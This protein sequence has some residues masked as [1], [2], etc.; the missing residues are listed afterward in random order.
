MSFEPAATCCRF[1][2]RYADALLQGIPS[3]RWAEQPI[4]GANHPAWLLGHLTFAGDSGCQLLGGES[5]LPEGWD[6]V[7][8]R[9]THPSTNRSDYP[10]GEDIHSTFVATYNRLAE[11]AITADAETLA[12]PNPNKMLKDG[13]LPT[14]GDLVMFLMTGHLS[15]HLGQLSAWR[16]MIGMPPLF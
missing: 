7:Y 1:M 6:K 3:E 2:L 15:L 9:G 11:L 12:G 16:R 14:V 13:G 10:P 5:Q 4:E 8:G